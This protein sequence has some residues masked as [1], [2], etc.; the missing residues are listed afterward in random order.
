MFFE[1]E[2]VVIGSDLNALLFA[3]I[4]KHP[5]LYTEPKIPHEFEFLDFK[6]DMS[7][8]KIDNSGTT[9]KTINEDIR[10]GVRKILLWEKLNFL[11]SFEGL[12][13]LS[14]ICDNI[15]YDGSNLTCSSEYSK[16]CEIKFDKCYYF[17]DNKT[18]KLVT[19]RKS[20]N[21]RY[22][23]FDRVGFHS[24]GKHA[25]EYAQT[26]DDFVG[27]VWFYSSDRIHGDTGVKDACALSTLTFDQLSDNSFTQ[28][29]SAFKVCDILKKNGIRGKICG[30]NK[31]GTTRHRSYRTSNIDR[32]VFLIDTPDWDETDNI[33]KN[34]TTIEELVEIANNMDLSHYKYINGRKL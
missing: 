11:L 8:L 10:F 23:V 31:D 5:I 20:K 1:Y 2:N 13:P 32:Q 6:C 3:F 18:Y 14:N 30:Y 19:E 25:L 22:K 17:G 24:G 29:M 34:D 28:T 16:L 15:R 9:F 4:N 7:F 27:Q 21:E 12:C 26:S 33:K